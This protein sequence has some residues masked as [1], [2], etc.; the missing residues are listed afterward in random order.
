[1]TQPI[2]CI[3]PE[4]GLSD[5]IAKGRERR[6]DIVPCP[7]SVIE[8]VRWTAPDPSAFDALL[9][10]SA[11]VFRHGGEELAEMRALPVYAVGEATANTAREAG[12]PVAKTGRGGLQSVIDH[13]A[14]QPMRYLRLGGEERVPLSLPTWQSMEEI[15]VYRSKPLE[16]PEDRARLLKN[17]ACVLLHSAAAARHFT[18]ECKRLEL[19]KTVFTLLALGPRIAQA[20]GEGWAE[21]AI[22]DTPTDD[23]LLALAE[24]MCQ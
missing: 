17:G 5:T 22:A 7:L 23:A 21:I 6:L 3:R 8:S 12:F 20:A 19:D 11:N 15:A 1:M 18:H 24:N 4:P 2:L 10:G 16:L 9:I 13:A 14:V